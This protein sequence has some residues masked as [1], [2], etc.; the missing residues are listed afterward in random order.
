MI[1]TMKRKTILKHSDFVTPPDS[2]IGRSEF[3]IIRT[4]LPT[5]PGDARYGL[6]APK[7]TFK[8]AVQRNR[9]KR[10][11]RDWIAYNE[12]LMLPC[13]DYI[14]IACPRILGAQRDLGRERM[15]KSLKRIA[16]TYRIYGN[17]K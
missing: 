10:L 12:D 11:L 4:K 15:R 16:K 17:Q 9:A 13:L 3:F 2:I 1:V 8:L 5:I 14:F 7:R 6:V